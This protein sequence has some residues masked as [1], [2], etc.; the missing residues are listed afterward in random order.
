[1]FQG[2]PRW[3]EMNGGG[4]G[5]GSRSNREPSSFWVEQMNHF[6]LGGSPTTTTT[7][8]TG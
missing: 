7:T 3:E 1:M 2:G 6:F 4:E 5:L 8:T